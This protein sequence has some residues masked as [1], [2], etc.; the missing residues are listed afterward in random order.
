MFGDS[1]LGV[2][3]DPNV[4]G[5]A[6]VQ[7]AGST[8]N[9]ILDQPTALRLANGG[10]GGFMSQLPRLCLPHNAFNP[11][12]AAKD[13]IAVNGDSYSVNA[14]VVS[15]DGAIFEYQLKVSS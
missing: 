10:V 15:E 1:D 13:T 4:F 6:V 3:F 14:P 5:D 12:P 11:M 8:A 2:F 9:G 7:F